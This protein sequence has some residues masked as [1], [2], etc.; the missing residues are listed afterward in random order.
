MGTG[1]FGLGYLTP[2]ILPHSFAALTLA[3]GFTLPNRDRA[4]QTN[5]TGTFLHGPRAQPSS[6]MSGEREGPH[7]PERPQRI[8]MGGAGVHSHPFS[9]AFPHPAVWIC[10]PSH[11]RCQSR[12]FIST[13]LRDP[14]CPNH[15]RGPPLKAGAAPG[16]KGHSP[17]AGQPLSSF[18]IP[19]ILMLVS[20]MR[21][22]SQHPPTPLVCAR[23]DFSLKS[24]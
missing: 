4:M 2:L 22:M 7:S 24:E 5:P 23:D 10:P 1:I 21:L 16:G 18:L 3:S 6:P 12:G 20:G 11:Y 9:P 14:P 13:P 8:A 19:L 15:P 17:S